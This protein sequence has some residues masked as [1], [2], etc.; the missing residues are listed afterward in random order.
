[1]PAAD[2]DE[3]QTAMDL[4]AEQLRLWPSLSKDKQQELVKNEESTVFSQAIHYASLMVYLLVP[5]DSSKNK[6]LRNTPATDWES[7][8]NSIVTNRSGERFNILN[9]T[10]T[11]L[12]SFGLFCICKV[13]RLVLS[14]RKLPCW[15]SWFGSICAS[16][17]KVMISMWVDVAELAVYMIPSYLAKWIAAPLLF[18]DHIHPV[19]SH[20]YCT[21]QVCG[22]FTS[23]GN[24]KTIRLSYTGATLYSPKP[25]KLRV[26]VISYVLYQLWRQI[27]RGRSPP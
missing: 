2:R 4:A 19:G 6:L 8:S 25:N 23:A 17:N 26:G 16:L 22:S 14:A 24:F 3:E 11:F 18:P 21:K 12:M 9:P 13:E 1:M 27:N 10:A 20:R 7:G 5:L 15:V